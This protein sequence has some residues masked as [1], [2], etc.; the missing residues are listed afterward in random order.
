LRGAAFLALDEVVFALPAVALAVR[1]FVDLAVFVLSFAL[2]VLA[3]LTWAGD[4]T[5]K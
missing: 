3:D 4:S 1:V 5:N 2:L